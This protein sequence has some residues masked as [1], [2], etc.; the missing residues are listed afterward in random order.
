MRSHIVALC[1]FLALAGCTASVELH[2]D[3]QD[4]ED[5]VPESE[6]EY[7]EL[8][9][10]TPSS[11]NLDALQGTWQPESNDSLCEAELR[12]QFRDGKLRIGVRWLGHTFGVSSD[13][14]ER[15]VSNAGGNVRHELVLGPADE[16][17]A[18]I[19]GRKFELSLP[20]GV[21]WVRAVAVHEQLT[22]RRLEGVE[23]TCDPAQGSA[24][25]GGISNALVKL[26]D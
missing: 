12:Y 3:D 10:I 6:P 11:A 24:C 9:A 1:T 23:L 17:K 22:G 13:Y 26:A 14:E 19:D 15:D 8:F 16:V 7:E 5:L 21:H 20:A 18:R 4:L 25:T 2:G